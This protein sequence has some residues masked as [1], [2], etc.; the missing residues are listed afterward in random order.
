MHVST[1]S[2]DA[3]PLVEHRKL[4][5]AV[6]VQSRKRKVHHGLAGR[7]GLCPTRPPAAW[8]PLLAIVRC[9]GRGDPRLVPD[10]G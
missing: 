10:Q 8:I 9:E 3:S 4:T 2:R 7:L 1:T 5:R 6:Q